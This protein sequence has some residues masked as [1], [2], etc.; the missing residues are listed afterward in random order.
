MGVWQSSPRGFCWHGEGLQLCSPRDS[1]VVAAGVRDARGSVQPEQELCPHSC[2]KVKHVYSACWIP[3]GL[4]HVTNPVCDFHGQ[5]L[6]VWLERGVRLVWKLQ[7]CR[8]CGSVGF[9][10]QWSLASTRKICV[11]VEC[12]A[13]P[14]LRPGFSTE[15]GW[16]F[17]PG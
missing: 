13:P 5:D 2:L 17:P 3:P 7:G 15:K 1:A 16:I 6:G 4:H 14:S 9:F 10:K 12:E 8:P 11:W